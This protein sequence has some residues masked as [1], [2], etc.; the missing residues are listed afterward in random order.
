MTSHYDPSHL[1]TWFLNRQWHR[2]RDLIKAAKRAVVDRESEKACYVHWLSEAGEIIHEGWVP[3]SAIELKRDSMVRIA[4]EEEAK[5]KL[6]EWM[7]QQGLPSDGTESITELHNKALWHGKWK[8][9]PR[10]LQRAG[11]QP[12]DPRGDFS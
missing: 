3:K 12:Y 5:T 8:T 1:R 7:W 9:M 6:R 4:G 11:K 2:D 10:E